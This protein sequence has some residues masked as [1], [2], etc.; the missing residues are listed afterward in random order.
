MAMT[1][2]QRLNAILH[3]QPVDRL[4]WTT[5]V[6][7]TTLDLM[8]PE[9][10]GNGGLDLYRHLGCDIFLLDSWGLPVGFKSPQLVWGPGVSVRSETQGELTSTEWSTP[11]GAL[12]AVW[13]RNHP[14]QYPVTTLQE[15]RLYREMWEGAHYAA[16]DDAAAYKQMGELLGEDGIVTRFWG[17][18]TIPHLL[19]TA[20]GTEAFYYLLNDYPQD[21]EGLINAIHSCELGAFQALAAGPVEVAILC[22]NT[23]SYYIGPEVYRLYNGP[24]VAD[25]CRIIRGAGKVAIVHMCGHIRNLLPQIARTGLQGVNG[26]TPPP[27]GDCPW[28]LYLDTIGEDQIIQGVLE[29]TVFNTGT[30]EEIWRTLDALYTPRIRRSRLTLW[31]AADGLPVPLWRFEAVRDW[32]ERNG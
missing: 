30:V 6:D 12:R 23:S 21:M 19:E 32:M 20:M 13:R 11:R 28:E 3:G 29:P 14:S 26:L 31:A 1:G 25:F 2:R 16:C 22:E 17:P 7:S 10:R 9:L 18:S 4:S 15:V 8:P 5:L 24:H 27:V